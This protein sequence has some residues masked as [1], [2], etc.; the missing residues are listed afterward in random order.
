MICPSKPSFF[1]HFSMGLS[2]F[3]SFS[4]A[5]KRCRGLAAKAMDDAER[6]S[7]SSG[8]EDSESSASS[9]IFPTRPLDDG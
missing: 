1:H 4:A 2:E 7:A 9:T 5:S 8:S 6:G 3:P